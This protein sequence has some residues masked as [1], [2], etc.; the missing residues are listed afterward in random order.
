MSIPDIIV[1]DNIAYYVTSISDKA[2]KGNKKLKKVVIGSNISSV[3]KQAFLN[4]RKLK[5]ITILSLN[6]KIKKK[7]FYGIYGK[8]KIYIPAEKFA[9]YR[10]MLKKS[11]IKAGVKIKKK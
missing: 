2:L 11:K 1:S 8:A 4:C 10:K 7:A 9:A 5:K 3:G 6:I